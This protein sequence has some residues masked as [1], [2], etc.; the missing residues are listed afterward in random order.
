[1]FWCGQV[2]SEPKKGK[3]T[4]QRRALHMP[5]AHKKKRTKMGMERARYVKADE[6]SKGN[7]E[8]R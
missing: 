6:E 4:K 8:G 5:V 3:I 2:T 1:M 7:S